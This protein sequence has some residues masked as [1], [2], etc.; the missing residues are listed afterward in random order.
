MRALHFLFLSLALAACG[1][2]PAPEPRASAADGTLD[3]SELSDVPE[4]AD[5][6]PDYYSR[7]STAGEVPPRVG[8]VAGPEAAPSRVAGPGEIVRFETDQIGVVTV[9]DGDETYDV[10]V[11]RMRLTLGTEGSAASA[12][13]IR[14][15]VARFAPLESGGPFEGVDPAEVERDRTALLSFLFS[16]GSVQTLWIQRR[17]DGL[18]VLARSGGTVHR[19]P[20]DRFRDLVPEPDALR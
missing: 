15:W 10:N 2:D 3:P 11:D 1:S 4:G 17:A 19:L 13:A 8:D 7:E 6:A 14:R 18:A 12:G 5:E 9:E 16:D 20:A